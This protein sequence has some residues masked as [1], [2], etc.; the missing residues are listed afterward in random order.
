MNRNLERQHALK[1][2]DDKARYAE[3]YRIEGSYHLGIALQNI[4]LKRLGKTSGN[5]A[6]KAPAEIVGRLQNAIETIV[7][8][9]S[10][11]PTPEAKMR[12]DK[13]YQVLQ[14]EFK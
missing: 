11:N 7:Y 13:A 12:L 4:V 2:S 5:G 14:S 8:E 10:S 3:I 1:I 6:D 9:N